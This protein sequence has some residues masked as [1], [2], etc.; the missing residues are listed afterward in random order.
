MPPATPPEDLPLPADERP[1]SLVHVA[2][3][4]GDLAV[5]LRLFADLLG[6]REAGRGED[7]ASRWVDLTWPDAGRIRLIEPRGPASPLASS[8]AASLVS[9]IGARPGRLH[10][11][12]FTVPDPATVPGAS[13]KDDGLWEVAPESNFGVRVLL[14][15]GL[16]GSS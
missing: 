9:W 11:L 13:P 3:A 14:R 5:G 6:G 16:P 12:A 1:T 8:L 2:H 10:H 7:G 15:R 4:V